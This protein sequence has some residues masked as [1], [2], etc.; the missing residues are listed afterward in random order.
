MTT[1]CRLDRLAERYY[2][3]AD[4]MTSL[5]FMARGYFLIWYRDKNM[6]FE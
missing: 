3:T 5:F 2:N 4:F 1:M 6:L